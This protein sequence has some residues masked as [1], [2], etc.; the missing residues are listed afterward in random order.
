MS[1]VC[2]GSKKQKLNTGSSV[3]VFCNGGSNVAI[4]SANNL[5]TTSS[6]HSRSPT[7]NCPNA[8]NGPQCT[9]PGPNCSACNGHLHN[10]CNGGLHSLH[11]PHYSTSSSCSSIAPGTMANGPCHPM[12][13]GCA[14]GCA[15]A[16][17]CTNTLL[18]QSM[19]GMYLNGSIS[20]GCPQGCVCPDGPPCPPSPTYSTHSSCVSGCLTPLGIAVPSLVPLGFGLCG[21]GTSSPSHSPTGCSGVTAKREMCFYCF[22]VLHAYLF[23]GEQPRKP[24][25]TDES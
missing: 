16:C 13:M 14:S 6:T 24:S 25:F 4:N 1:S 11:S 10:A 8:P 7:P 18:P 3:S 12:S 2:C 17:A 15:G 5:S 23:G 21:G 20:H 19:N 22:D 9:G